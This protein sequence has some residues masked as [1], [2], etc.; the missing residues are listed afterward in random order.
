[1]PATNQH[2]QWRWRNQNNEETAMAVS[3]QEQ[4]PPDTSAQSTSDELVRLICKLR[5]IGM[6]D[7]AKQLSH[8]LSARLDKTAES[9][10]ATPGETD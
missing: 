1:V 8:Q 6:E 7:E 9:V 2:H 4:K 3:L 10:V 5:W